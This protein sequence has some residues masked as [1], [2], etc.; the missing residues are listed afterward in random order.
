MKKSRANATSRPETL[1]SEEYFKVPREIGIGTDVLEDRVLD[2]DIGSSHILCLL[3]SGLVW[4]CGRNESCQ[5]AL[6]SSNIVNEAFFPL[7]TVPTAN[8]IATLRE[9][10]IIVGSDSRC[11]IWG[12]V[13]LE[14]RGVQKFNHF[15]TKMAGCR[16]IFNFFRNQ[17]FD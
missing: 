1:Y 10:S 17:S 11:Y 6:S 7:T 16:K 15:R 13:S 3:Q 5:L 12:K 2:F 14:Y 8:H 9:T 4:G